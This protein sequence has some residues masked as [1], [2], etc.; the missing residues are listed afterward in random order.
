MPADP[1][2]TRPAELVVTC[3]CGFEARGEPER[4]IPLVQQ[5]GRDVHN[6]STTAEQVLALARPADQG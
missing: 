2:E 3:A 1:P 6:M 5:H 4:L